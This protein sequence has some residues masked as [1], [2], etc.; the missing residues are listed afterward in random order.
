MIDAWADPQTLMVEFF[1][2][3]KLLNLLRLRHKPCERIV[4]DYL[5]H[6]KLSLVFKS[7]RRMMLLE[8][9]KLVR[10]VVYI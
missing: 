5:K 4:T 6:L 1:M 10:R 9:V 2:H 8:L 3:V 7:G